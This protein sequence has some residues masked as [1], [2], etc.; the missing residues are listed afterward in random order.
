MCGSALTIILVVGGWPLRRRW[1]PS[2]RWAIY[3]PSPKEKCRLFNIIIYTL[4]ILRGRCRA[5][6]DIELP[7]D[8]KSKRQHSFRHGLVSSTVQCRVCTATL[9]RLENP[10]VPSNDNE[11][12][13]QTAS[14]QT[15]RFDWLIVEHSSNRLVYPLVTSWKVENPGNNRQLGGKR[16]SNQLQR[17]PR[18]REGH[19]QLGV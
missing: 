9:L 17:S 8:L 15:A 14:V 12:Q 3:R 6:V 2:S 18:L 4:L 11:V 19:S 16:R 13:A 1:K 10:V 5:G 7:S